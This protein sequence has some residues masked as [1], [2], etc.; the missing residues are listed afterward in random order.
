MKKKLV[1]ALV[2]F[3]AVAAGI[4]YFLTTGNV[5]KKYNTAQVE[6]G[7]VGRFIQETGRVSSMNI[8]KYYGNSV[9]KVETLNV[10][11]GDHVK[12]GQ[13]LIKYEDDLDIEIRKVEKQ[14]E[15]LEATYSSVTSGTDIENINSAKIEISRINRDIELATKNK[16][17]IQ[18]LYN[19]GAVPLVELEQV[20]NNI[21]Q[22]ES[23]LEV[24]QN[25]YNQLIKGVSE[26]TRKIYEAEIDVLLLTLES[27]ERRKEKSQVYSDIDGIVTEF[28]T[29]VGDIPLAGSMI[30]EIQDPNAKVVLVDF[31]VEEAL[32]VKPHMRALLVDQNM[33]VNMDNLKVNRIFP[34]AFI[35]MSELSVEENRQTVEIGI[36]NNEGELPFGLELNTRVII[37]EA[38]ESLLIP[39]DAVYVKNGSK[40]VEVLENGEP[41][42]RRIETGIEDGNHIEVKQGLTEGEEVILKYME[43]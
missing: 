4:F 10:Q 32:L 38:E 40:Y 37:D 21:V 19:N 9:K 17:R 34:K 13:L 1:I 27:I 8:R 36:Y 3:T 28:N 18:E 16:D 12:S 15:A 35:T 11:L 5:G 39:K 24:A 22:L 42:E 7:E 25:N 23:S 6:K 29:F 14:I 30:L 2:I 43:D 26:S 41:V 20:Q 33:G 31:M